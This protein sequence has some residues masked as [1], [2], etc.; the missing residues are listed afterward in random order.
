MPLYHVTTGFGFAVHLHLIVM[1]VPVSFGMIFGFSI[2]EGAKPA[3]SSPPVNHKEN[4]IDS[5]RS[6]V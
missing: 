1:S 3:P 4:Y 5:Y 6:H 2:K